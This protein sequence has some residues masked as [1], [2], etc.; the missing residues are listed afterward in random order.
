M[1]HRFVIAIGAGCAAAL[2][3][4]VSAQ[5]SLL[6]MALA[7]LAPLPIMIATSASGSTRARRRGDF[8][9]AL[10]GVVRTVVRVAVR[11]FR[12]RPG[13]GPGRLRDLPGPSIFRRPAAGGA[14]LK[15][16]SA[17]S[18]CSRRCS[19][20]RERCGA[21]TVIIVYRGY[22]EG[23]RQVA[24]TVAAARCRG[25]ESAPDTSARVISLLRW[26]EWASGDLRLDA[27]DA[28]RQPLRRRTLNP[29]VA[30]LPR[31]WPICRRRSP[32]PGRSALLSSPA[33]WPPSS[34]RAGRPIF[35]DRRRQASAALVLQGLAVA[36]ALS[37]GL[38]SGL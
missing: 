8:G 2:L 22:N 38:S 11:G 1:L 6:A 34:P 36:H 30:H 27:A 20:C 33:P 13:L 26:S 31:P 32:C 35:L 10:G 37:R 28:V 12:G 18:S 23:A 15:P 29:A 9:A 19:E 24:S 14:Q 7:Y 17:P 4:V 5:P 3:F 25:V 16:R 21:T